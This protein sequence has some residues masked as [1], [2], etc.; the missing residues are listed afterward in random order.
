MNRDI[1]EYFSALGFERP[2]VQKIKARMPAARPTPQIP[3]APRVPEKIIPATPRLSWSDLENQAKICT[4]CELS[5][6][7]T[8][9]VFGAGAQRARLMFVGEAPGADED[10]QGIPFVGR[11]G[12]LLDKMIVAMGLSREN[13]VYI[14][15]VVKC[16]PPDN[17]NPEPAEIKACTDF[18]QRQIELVNPEIVVALGSVAAQYLLQT[19][20]PL[21]KLRGRFADSPTF[22]REDGQKVS[23]MATYHPAF[24]LRNPDMKK[25][26]WEDLQ[27]VMAKLGATKN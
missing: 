4:S 26:V 2:P 3:S 12:Q 9:V 23:V 6:G 10:A 5:R 13:D 27:K 17:R 18:L 11:A 7:R 15:N 21:G 19:E 14:A 1:Y 24:L 8:Q 20:L 22:T 16:R 25:P